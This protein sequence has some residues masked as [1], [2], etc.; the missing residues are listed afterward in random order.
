MGAQFD[1]QKVLTLA[2]VAVLVLDEADRMLDMG[3]EKDIRS[4]VDQLAPKRQTLFFTAT[5]PKN[6]QRIASDIL[7]PERLQINIGDCN[8]LN[9]NKD[10]NQ[11]RERESVCA[12]T[13]T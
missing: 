4:I 13:Y 6:V 10:V 5:W 8:A 7:S 12:Q 11:V 2:K 3:F 1:N 9:A